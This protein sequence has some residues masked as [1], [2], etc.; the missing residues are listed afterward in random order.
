MSDTESTAVSASS[1]PL[2]EFHWHVVARSIVTSFLA[3]AAIVA[4]L[5]EYISSPWPLLVVC[6]AILGYNALLFLTP[7]HR[8]HPQPA[9]LMSLVLDLVA[10]TSYLHYSGDIENPLFLAYSLPVVAGAVLLSRRSGFFLA[11]CAVF[12]FITL[13]LMTILDAFPIHVEHHHLALIGNLYLHDRIDP[14]LN[15]Q[16]WNYIL[17]H[18]LV[19]AAVLFGSAHGFGTLSSRLRDTERELRHENERLLLLLSILPEGVVL[20]APDGA[21]LHANPAAKTLLNG[22][23]SRSIRTLD[24]DLGLTERFIGFAGL[25]ESFESLYRER[26]LEHALARRSPSGPIVWV[27]RDTTDQRRLMA[28]VMHRSKMI[29]LG[30]L[31]AGIA[32]E[33]GNPLSSMSAILQVMEMKQPTSEVSERIRSLNSHVDRIGRIVQDITS[34]ARPSAGRRTPADARALLAKA[35]QIFQFHDKAKEITVERKLPGESVAVEVI[36]DQ[37]VQVLLN[38]L[39]NASDAC[40]G[41]GIVNATV[42]A[43][44]GEALLS[45]GDHGVGISEDGKRHLF[46]PFYTTKDQGKGVGMGLFISESIARGHRGRIDVVSATGKGSV[47]TLRL[48]LA[49]RID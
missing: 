1:P 5:F 28:Q 7:W 23:E 20:L 2:R 14:D 43:V 41:R 12:L 16:G 24:P 37:I 33:I 13:I 8:S 18:L 34:F 36:E 31:A 9:T 25:A 6:G 4:Y 44:G 11:A 30:I 10:L 22:S 29:D 15:Q 35:L 21:I 26:T 40:D 17:T 45:I 48:P 19:L 49:G 38:L 47:F 39:L 42:E 3:L 46:T 27:F 32:H